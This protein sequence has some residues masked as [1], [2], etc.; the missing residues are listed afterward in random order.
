MED[1]SKTLAEEVK[2]GNPAVIFLQSLLAG[3]VVHVGKSAADSFNDEYLKK[4]N[5][6]KDC[7]DPC[8]ISAIDLA[9]DIDDAAFT[10]YKNCSIKLRTL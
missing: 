9:A 6:M 7:F 1:L 5:K 3:V 8:V 2:G 10:C 4:D